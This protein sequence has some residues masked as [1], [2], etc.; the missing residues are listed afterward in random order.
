M[1]YSHIDAMDLLGV[2]V[3]LEIVYQQA[4]ELTFKTLDFEMATLPCQH[5]DPLPSR[6]ILRVGL[7]PLSIQIQSL[8]LGLGKMQRDVLRVLRFDIK[9]SLPSRHLS[10]VLA[11]FPPQESNALKLRALS[12]P[13]IRSDGSWVVSVT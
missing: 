5:D 13:R 6:I 3:G 12:E 4:S 9:I 11:Q 1:D 2:D 10:H 8:E 7:V